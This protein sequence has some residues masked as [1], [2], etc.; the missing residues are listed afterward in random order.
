MPQ[1]V[2]FMAPDGAMRWLNPNVA[3]I[4]YR[5]V[6]CAHQI[7]LISSVK[8]GHSPPYTSSTGIN[9]R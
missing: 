4:A 3:K 8:G 2:R 9:H 1:E 5:R 7:S 6:G